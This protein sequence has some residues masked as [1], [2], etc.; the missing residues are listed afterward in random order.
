MALPEAK[1]RL[2]NLDGEAPYLNHKDWIADLAALCAVYKDDVCVS[3]QQKDTSVK[4]MI[5]N[6]TSSGKIGFYFNSLRRLDLVPPE[7]RPQ[8]SSGT[9]GVEENE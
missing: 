3:T 7:Q 5:W 8:L 4:K 9:S 1:R 2:S 6:M